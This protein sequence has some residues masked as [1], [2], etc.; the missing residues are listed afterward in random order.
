MSG[1]LNLRDYGPTGLL[2]E[3]LG[4]GSDSMS[5][6][7]PRREDEMVRSTQVRTKMSAR[8]V[9]NLRMKDEPDGAEKS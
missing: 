1:G 5:D 8:I 6:L 3:P 7:I 9:V 4:A 2:A